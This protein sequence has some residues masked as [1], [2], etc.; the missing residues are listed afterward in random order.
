LVLITGAAKIF[1]TRWRLSSGTHRKITMLLKLAF[2]NVFRQ[3]RRTIL[4]AL[5]M[6]GGFTLAAI[7]IAWSDGTYAYVIDMFT[8]NRL[9]HIQIHAA[10]YLDKPSLYKTIDDF[11]MVGE[12]IQQVARIE[13]WTPRLY[14]AGLASVAE[15]S[16]GVQIIGIDPE[17]EVVATR[18]DKKISQG[19]IFST[20]P[21]PEAILGKGLA[22]VLH[23]EIGDE[24]VIVSQAADGSIANDL[25]H[26]VGIVAS[27]DEF[28]D[29]MAFYLHLQ[30]AQELL[31]LDGR[32]HEIAIIAKNLDQIEALT[33]QIK[34]ALSDSN[35]EVAPWQEFAKSFYQA[36]QAD[37]QGNWISLFI[38]LLIVAVGVLNTVLMSV[39]ERTREYGVL[40]AV[41][42]RPA[43]IFALVLCEV[44]IIALTSVIAGTAL[45]FLINSLLSRHGISM[46]ETFTYGGVEFS[47]M[48]TAVN[49]RSFYIPALT[50]IFAANF[51]ST[52]PALKAARI[53][54]ALAMRTH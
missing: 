15:K 44:N 21:S 37:V 33:Q 12:K 35:L 30:D 29:R 16:A 23:A 42:T 4:T 27:G 38:I 11:E 46:P 48:Y 8:R 45:S 25:Y 40:K 14:S 5:T 36:M 2:R 24:I 50:V 31:V 28:S 13:A 22:K 20:K 43:S 3:K 51:I 39:L 10:G 52:F 18:F 17:R 6:L 41:G 53:E 32:V 34:S 1:V 9:G 26:V 7:S 54:P 19:R 49:A 47:K